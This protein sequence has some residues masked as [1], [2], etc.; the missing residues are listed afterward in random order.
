[1]SPTLH[2]VLGVL[3]GI[4]TVLAP[5]AVLLRR[6]RHALHLAL[7]EATHDDTTGLPNRRAALAHLRRLLHAGTPCGVVLLDLDDFKAI[8]DT[9]GHETG[10]DLLRAVGQRLA[11]LEA[12]VVLA[13]R[14]SGD[15]FVLIVDGDPD[16]VAHTAHAAWAALVLRAF[17]LDTRTG[18]DTGVTARVRAS[19]GHTQARLGIS[20]RDLLREADQAMY[21]AK[22][23][24]ANVRAH[25][26]T[27]ATGDE[28]PA[29][30]PAPR[31]RDRR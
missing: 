28:H 6:R 2:T 20:P 13:G 17:L 16:Q 12:P 25:T 8:N 14:L 3:A 26:P 23:T 15:E 7:H 21:R 22:T 10:N 1:M 18:T 19:V 5:A 31:F 27:P 9:F 11:A 30:R 24:G 29:R 4:L